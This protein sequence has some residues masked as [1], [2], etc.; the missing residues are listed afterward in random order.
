MVGLL[1]CVSL[2]YAEGDCTLVLC[3]ASVSID[4]DDLLR[5]ISGV[6]ADEYAENLKSCLLFRK[7][8]EYLSRPFIENFEIRQ[9]LYEHI[10][11]Y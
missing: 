4:I 5:L 9:G 6:G 8:E 1:D 7:M 3:F 11:W 10:R 2:W